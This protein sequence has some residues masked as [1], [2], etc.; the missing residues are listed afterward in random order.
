MKDHWL[1]EGLRSPNSSPVQQSQLSAPMSEHNSAAAENWSTVRAHWSMK[2]MSTG[3]MEVLHAVLM[4]SWH[5]V[6]VE[7]RF[8]S[9][10]APSVVFFLAQV[11]LVTSEEELPPPIVINVAATSP[12]TDPFEFF[13]PATFIFL[14]ILLLCLMKFPATSF[15]ILIAVTAV[16][17]HMVALRLH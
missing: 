14:L 1:L 12:N 11:R 10:L 5:M 16:S 13:P 15:H 7:V 17:R 3:G 2:A 8:C 6:R 9:C 4:F